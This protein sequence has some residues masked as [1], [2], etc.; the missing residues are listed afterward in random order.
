MRRKWK[1]VALINVTAMLV[2]GGFSNLRA[3]EPCGPEGCDEFSYQC[4]GT[5]TQ[6]CQATGEGC[7][8]GTCSCIENGFY[9]LDCNTTGDCIQNHWICCRN[10]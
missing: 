2:G 9:P 5:C 10:S 1:L 3:T 6:S 7:A 4:N 8:S